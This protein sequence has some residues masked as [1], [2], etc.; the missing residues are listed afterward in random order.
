MK[1]YCSDFKCKAMS[2]S[3][4]S[5]GRKRKKDEVSPVKHGTLLRTSQSRVPRSSVLTDAV[6]LRGQQTFRGRPG[7]TRS[8]GAFC[9]PLAPSLH[10]TLSRTER[11]G[12]GDRACQGLPGGRRQN[13]FR[14][15]PRPPAAD[16]RPHGPGHQGQAAWGSGCLA[17]R[18]AA[19]VV[20]WWG[21]RVNDQDPQ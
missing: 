8:A 21:P 20:R 16:V 3:S 19:M 15:A 12:R 17:F 4:V 14:L 5:R 6:A 7:H 18:S 2:L 10:H 1:S 13:A 9:S 11:G